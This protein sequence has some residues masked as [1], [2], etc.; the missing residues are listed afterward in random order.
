MTP[1]PDWLRAPAALPDG[2]ARA[3][4]AVH[5]LALTKPPGAPGRLEAVAIRLASLQRLS[6]PV[7]RRPQIC[8][9]AADHGVVQEGVSA[10]PQEV[11]AQMVLNM[12][13]G[14]A[15]ISVLARET[16][17]AIEL[18]SLGTVMHIAPHPLVREAVI[19]PGTAN[20]ARG[21]AMTDAQL[22]QALGEGRAACE[23]ALADRRDLFIGG[24]MGIGNTTS[25]SA[26]ACAL[27]GRPAEDLVGP[28][29]GLD[30]PGI[31]RKR[32]VVAQALALHRVSADDPLAAL[33]CMGGF[34]IAALAGAFV[35]CAQRRLPMLIDGFITS[36][37]ALAAV[38]ICRG[39]GDWM[40]LGHVSAEPGHRCVVAALEAAGAEAPLLDLG[41][42]L[43]EGSG[44]AA[45]LPLVRLAC[46]LHAEMATFDQAGVAPK[47]G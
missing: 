39:A 20:F 24:E 2:D 9:F 16:G 27:L 23:R 10:F 29:T 14:G 38:R 46:A 13:R 47:S 1:R 44:A 43:G 15:A 33:R 7:V 6:K 11:T 37:A 41:M 22:A 4:A 40:L 17:S 32:D 3:G 42:R 21:A 19:G 25:A 18:I 34:E 8:V 45:A 31:G 30:G 35:A 12:A 36:V 26:L 28:G 5:Q